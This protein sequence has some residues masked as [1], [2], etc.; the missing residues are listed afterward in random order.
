MEYYRDDPNNN[1][2]NS[3]SFK[4]KIRI[5]GKTPTACNTKGVKKAVLLSNL[6]NY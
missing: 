2:V 1:L 6:E 3:A 4:S 5:T